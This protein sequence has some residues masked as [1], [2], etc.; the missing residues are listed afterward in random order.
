M[1]VKALGVD[2]D[3]SKSSSGKSSEVHK[4]IEM[5]GGLRTKI[6][7]KGTEPVKSGVPKPIYTD[8]G[9]RPAKSDD[10]K[11][12]EIKM[13]RKPTLVSKTNSSYGQEMAAEAKLGLS[14]LSALVKTVT[15]IKPN[16]DS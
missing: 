8:A 7:S 10:S 5:E 1:F 3:Q 13:D 16:L 15:G 2:K 9:L 14:S 6:K 12:L 11:A 4:M